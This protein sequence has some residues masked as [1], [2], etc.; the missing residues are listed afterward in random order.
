MFRAFRIAGQNFFLPPGTPK[1]RAQILQDAMRRT[2]T[3]PEFAK[4]YEKT[5]GDEASPLAGDAL[6]KVIRE[7]PREAA[8]VELFNKLAGADPLPAR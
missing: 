5:A 8:V 1:E 4:E 6:E 3:D 2:L 7:L